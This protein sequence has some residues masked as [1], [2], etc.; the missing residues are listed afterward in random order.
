MED[1]AIVQGDVVE[2]SNAITPAPEPT[3]IT[4][5]SAE[6]IPQTSGAPE[7]ERVVT[8]QTESTL[9]E[10]YVDDARA[11]SYANK[12]HG[13]GDWI[14]NVYNYDQQQAG[15]MWV[16]GKINDVNT[17]MSF[18]EAT[19]NEDM[20]SELD[21]QKY[22]FDT[23]LATARAYAKEKLNE[24]A[25]GYYRAAQEKALAE[26]DLTGWY[27]PAEANYML[28]QWAVAGEK[29]KDPNSTD[30]DKARAN[31]VRSNVEDW[32]NANNITWR[33][34]ECINHMYYQE[35]VRHNA[36]M[37][38]LQAQ[39]NDIADRQNKANAAASGNLYDLQLRQLEFNMAELELDYGYDITGD[40][41][42]GHAG[43]DAGRFGFYNTEQEWA[44][45][46]L[47]AGFNLYG[48]AGMRNILGNRFNWANNSYHEQIQKGKWFQELVEKG[49][50]YIDVAS[51]DSLGNL[52]IKESELS[53]IPGVMKT[54]DIDKDAGIKIVYTSPGSASLYM[55]TKDGVAIR[56][57]DENME[58][59]NGKTIKDILSNKGMTLDISSPN[60]ITS[61]DKDSNSVTLNIGKETYD[62]FSFTPENNPEMFPEFNEKGLKTYKELISKGY[63]LERGLVDT[64]GGHSGMVFSDTDIDG[65]KTYY[66]FNSETGSYGK[67][68]NPSS[69]VKVDLTDEG[70]KT[71]YYLSGRTRDGFLE[72]LVHPNK[73]IE[74]VA[75]NNNS[76]VL[77]KNGDKEICCYINN[78]GTI[79]A[80]FQRSGAYSNDMQSITEADVKKYLNIDLDKFKGSLE[81]YANN[82]PEEQY[83]DTKT[84]DTI[85]QEDHDSMT[86]KAK[87]E[88]ESKKN[89][90]ISS[91][92]TASSTPK[93][94]SGQTTSSNSKKEKSSSKTE[95]KKTS[96][97]KVL[98]SAN[99]DLGEKALSEEEEK[100]EELKKSSSFLSSLS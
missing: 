66:A 57:N 61:K 99:A 71:S 76:L 25:Y 51:L 59:T 16:A 36:E 22:F 3:T 70:A 98:E 68:K 30:D 63:K 43:K 94:Q 69:I 95:E 86:E 14:K 77:G 75:V 39:A 62:K 31:S 7:Y 81:A 84:V 9:A 64:E 87:K 38:R 35:T 93:V 42:I 1:E 89:L 46:N 48:T 40:K 27:M 83:F 13:V 10:Q 91:N 24:T 12:G 58:L 34:I 11:N 32:F 60:S 41:V 50:T 100:R 8:P 28:S 96:E 6:S 92:S 23:N 90:A 49:N 21:L 74:L 80:Y 97:Q 17:Q 54:S 79:G 45:S 18:L 2:T 72:R 47:E 55:F 52:K 5:P 29:L 73:V 53:K 88:L 15:T 33:G 65:N 56:I 85:I 82:I 26:G 37:A 67:I 19:L 44:E 4:E 78:D 20:Y